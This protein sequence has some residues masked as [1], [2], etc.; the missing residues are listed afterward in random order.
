[1]SDIE[2]AP[3]KVTGRGT[4]DGGV[5]PHPPF[6]NYPLLSWTHHGHSEW[7]DSVFLEDGKACVHDIAM[8]AAVNQNLEAIAAKFNTTE[9]HVRQAI[10]YA[11]KAGFLA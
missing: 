6:H 8:E 5:N 10:E 1:M 3:L 4:C 2:T 9:E 7:G 11:V